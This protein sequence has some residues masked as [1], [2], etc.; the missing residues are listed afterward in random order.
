MNFENS[1]ESQTLVLDI[2]PFLLRTRTATWYIG[3]VR[4]LY[5]VDALQQDHT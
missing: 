4:I 3:K 2:T 1:I 5:Y